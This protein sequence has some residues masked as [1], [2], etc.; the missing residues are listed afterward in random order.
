V[1]AAE[2]KAFKLNAG[3]MSFFRV[4][5]TQAQ[6]AALVPHVATLTP[7]DRIGLVS[8][9]FALAKAGDLP[10]ATALQLAQG[11]AEEEEYAVWDQIC[12]NLGGLAKLY[13]AEEWYPAFQ[14]YI[15]TLFTP[16][17]A[18]LGWDSKE[19]DTHNTTQLRS[20]VFGMLGSVGKD[21]ATVAEGRRRFKTFIAAPT[22]SPTT[23]APDLRQLCYGLAVKDEDEAVATAAYEQLQALMVSS[24]LSEEKRRCLLA[25]GQAP[26]ATLMQRSL[27][28]ALDPAFVRPQDCYLPFAAVCS[29]AKGKQ[30]AWTFFQAKVETLKKQGGMGLIPHIVAF[31]TQ[32]FV[33]MEKYAEIEEFFKASP[34]SSAKRK[35]DQSLEKI[36]CNAGRLARE[37]VDVDAFLKTL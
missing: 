23:L 34:I 27:N 10:M 32:G 6:W 7:R 36:K 30:A 19:G 17:G 26:H 3:Q 22:A 14:K 21:P 25:M 11:Y 8:D 1:L 37:R 4:N 16:I 15:V 28:M 9:A 33:T 12:G 2:G 29:S 35:V 18:K 5:Y 20:L 24:E 13:A 31:V